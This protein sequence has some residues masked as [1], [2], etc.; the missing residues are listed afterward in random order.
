MKRSRLTFRRYLAAI[1]VVTAA[2][3]P[4]RAHAL[5]DVTSPRNADVDARG[6][7]SIRVSAGA[8][9]LRIVGRP[10]ITRVQ[11]R[12]TA[13]A[14]SSSA[15][16]DIKLIAERRGDVVFIKTDIAEENETFM[17]VIRGNWNQNRQLDLVIEVPETMPLQ[18]E[19]GSGESKFINV[20]PLNLVDGSGDLEIRGARGNVR[21]EDGSGDITIQNVE[22]SV[23]VSDGSGGISA[24]NIVGDFTVDDDGS[25]DIDVS[26][27]GGT[28][29]VE[30]DGSGNI[31][32]ER[33]AGDF[34]VDQKG[35]GSIRST[36][37]RGKIEIPE[38]HRRRG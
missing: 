27:V 19:D 37:V 11:V 30:N 20:G 10:G 21:V 26:S 16:S 33:I 35:S 6:A 4:V 5:A 32:V 18:V 38:R 28:M 31:D 1:L 36:G 7:T 22:G 8:G 14:S 24:S 15:L 2:F 29:R 34:I 25:G 9:D 3:I 23:H 12:G 13:R 17:G